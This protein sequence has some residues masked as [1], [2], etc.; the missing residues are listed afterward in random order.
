MQPR[1]VPPAFLSPALCCTCTS[2]RNTRQMPLPP[3]PGGPGPL[4]P[5]QGVDKW[6]SL[7]LPLISPQTYAGTGTVPVPL[8]AGSSTRSIPLDTGV[9]R[10]AARVYSKVLRGSVAEVDRRRPGVSQLCPTGCSQRERKLQRSIDAVEACHSRSRR[11]E[12]RARRERSVAEHE[13]RR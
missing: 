4:G 12:G 1:L 10:Y 6:N 7:Q 2:T 8:R 3:G 9:N 11:D 5:G 13:L